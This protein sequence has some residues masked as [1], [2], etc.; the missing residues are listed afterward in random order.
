MVETDQQQ[1]A[2]KD[3]NASHPIATAWRPT[4]REVVKSFAQGDFALAA[5]IRGV[6][7]IRP[8]ARTQ[9]ESYLKEYGKKLTELPDETWETSGAQWVEPTHW[10]I[11]VDLWTD[12]GK[13]DLVLAARVFEN[14]GDL[15]FEIDSVHV[16]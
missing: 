13:S 14:G 15:R 12:Q 11:D 9:I 3:R 4:L 5:G 2:I 6:A 7:P 10:E 1:A 16:P 8:R